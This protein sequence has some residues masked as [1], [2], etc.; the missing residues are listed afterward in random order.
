MKHFFV[1][2][3]IDRYC[4]TGSVV[5]RT[6]PKGKNFT[7]TRNNPKCKGQKGKIG[8][9]I[10]RTD[11]TYMQHIFLLG[12]KLL[13]FQKAQELTNAQKRHESAKHLVELTKELGSN[14]EL[15]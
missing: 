10:A 1:S 13:K 11:S 9:C 12:P 15:A 7:N 3:S 6:K 14:L 4:D 2:H 8:S 5:S